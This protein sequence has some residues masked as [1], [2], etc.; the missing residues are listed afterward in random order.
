MSNPIKAMSI[1]D[2]LAKIS[3]SL[4]K[5]HK[6]EKQLKVAGITAITLAIG[7]LVVLMTNIF[8][9]G[10]TALLQSEVRVNLEI[11][12]DKLLGEDGQI[13][14]QKSQAFNWSGLVKKSFRKGF[15]LVSN[16]KN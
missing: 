12:M 10:Y 13:D 6:R 14:P 11:P 1:E 8:S 3:K 7:F 5:R 9:N 4:D 16:K 2:R 15:Y